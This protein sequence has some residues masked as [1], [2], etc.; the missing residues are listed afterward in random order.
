MMIPSLPLPSSFKRSVPPLSDFLKIISQACPVG[1]YLRYE[2]LYDDI[3]LYRQEDDP[4]LSMGIWQTD[5]K[6]A[7]WGKIEALCS[8][9]LTTQTKD[10]QIAAWLTEAWTALDNLE[11]YIR[12]IHLFSSLVDTFWDT[13]YPQ[14]QEDGD[15]DKRLMIFEWMDTAFT[16][17]L[18]LVPLTQAKFEQTA[19]GMGFLKSAQHSNATQ[20]RSEKK[21]TSARIDPSK[22]MGTP[23]DFQKSLEQTP[24]VYLS[25]CHKNIQEATQETQKLK[26]ILSTLLG[27][28]S[29]SFSQ[30]LRTLKEMERI[31]ATTLQM[32]EPP[33]AQEPL[34]ETLET[35]TQSPDAPIVEDL[36][37]N[38]ASPEN[39]ASKLPLKT[40][41]DAYRQM[42]AIASFLEQT[43]PHSLAPQ[44]LHQLI[45]WQ[46]KN[47]LVILEEIAKTPQEHDILMKI[48]GRTS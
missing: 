36:L 6:R 10:L 1:S 8:E 23:D 20:K 14:P 27:A 25:G 13:V 40:R 26:D 15:M 5:P 30:T 34:P 48:L 12:G 4:R 18:L 38:S 35:T 22:E 43:D 46:N 28:A 47:I 21:K 29:P 7:D 11:G 9:A 31:V 39:P 33:P 42:E 44:L 37:S 24:D 3:R 16:S 45:R 32:R 2:H 41:E 17:R 19:F